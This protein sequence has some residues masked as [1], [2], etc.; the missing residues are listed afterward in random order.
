MAIR[1]GIESLSSKKFSTPSPPPP[2]PAPGGSAPKP[3]HPSH[4]DK[5]EPTAGVR[6][7]MKLQLLVSPHSQQ[8]LKGLS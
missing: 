1:A 3:Q 4:T 8:V 5:L 7:D 6:S 2:R